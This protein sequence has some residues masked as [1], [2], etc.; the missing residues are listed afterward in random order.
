[1][2]LADLQAL[3]ASGTES[4]TETA[5]MQKIEAPVRDTIPD[6]GKPVSERSWVRLSVFSTL[7]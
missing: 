4:L 6:G 1:M 7:H 2:R 3:D 5:V